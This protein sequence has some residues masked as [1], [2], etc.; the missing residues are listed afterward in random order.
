MAALFPGF[1]LACFIYNESDVYATEQASFLSGWARP[2]LI[3]DDFPLGGCY[4]SVLQEWSER[5]QQGRLTEG[6]GS[7]Q[8]TSSLG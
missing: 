6:E 7:V 8:L 2:L 3:S 1:K 4:Q 5:E